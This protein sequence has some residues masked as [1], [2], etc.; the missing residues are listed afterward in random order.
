MLKLFEFLAKI[1]LQR[2][3]SV[4]VDLEFL[5]STEKNGE[6]VLTFREMISE[7]G[8][9]CFV[10]LLDSRVNVERLEL[11][12]DGSEHLND[13]VEFLEA[14]VGNVLDVIVVVK[15]ENSL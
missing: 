5:E 3:N 8:S 13:Y 4:C 14:G 6:L 15:T 12:E 10:K 2:N 11:S 7:A 1:F 9:R